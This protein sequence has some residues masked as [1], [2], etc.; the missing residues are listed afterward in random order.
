MRKKLTAVNFL[1]EG[2]REDLIWPGEV[3]TIMK[4]TDHIEENPDDL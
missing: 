2:L 1:A 4:R 3:L